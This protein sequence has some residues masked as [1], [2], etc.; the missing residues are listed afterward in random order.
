MKR[1]AEKASRKKVDKIQH[2]EEVQVNDLLTE[3][4]ETNSEQKMTDS[5]G[6]GKKMPYLKAKTQ[7]TE[8][9]HKS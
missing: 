3:T 7:R 2:S 6:S 8:R 4:W 5:F 9:K 1:K